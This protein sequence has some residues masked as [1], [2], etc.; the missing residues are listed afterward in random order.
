[1]DLK[2][3]GSYFY[4]LPT[5]YWKFPAIYFQ[6]NICLKESTVPYKKGS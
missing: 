1:M 4:L 6:K 3:W 5:H 2:S